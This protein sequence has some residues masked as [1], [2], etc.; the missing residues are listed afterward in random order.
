MKEIYL[1]IF[2]ASEKQVLLTHEGDLPKVVQGPLEQAFD[3]AMALMASLG[4]ESIAMTAL[5]VDKTFEVWQP[6]G[7]AAKTDCLVENQ[8]ALSFFDFDH[9]YEDIK[10]HEWKRKVFKEEVIIEGELK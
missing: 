5:H 10:I 3:S 7:W 6:L 9:I 4:L 8:F 1:L 2:E